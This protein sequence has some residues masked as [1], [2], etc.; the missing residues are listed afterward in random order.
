MNPRKDLSSIQAYRREGLV[1]NSSDGINIKF[2]FQS[3]L[4]W[5]RI[6][7]YT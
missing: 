7:V 6:I 4:N 2:I 5:I 1:N 3:N